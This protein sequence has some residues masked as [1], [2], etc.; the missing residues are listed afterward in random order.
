MSFSISPSRENET[1]EKIRNILGMKEFSNNNDK[2]AFDDIAKSINDI[3]DKIRQ[4]FNDLFKRAE[5]PKFNAKLPHF[6]SND[7]FY[8]F[9]QIFFVILVI[10]LILAIIYFVSRFFIKNR[11][12]KKMQ[13][14]DI[15]TSLKDWE[16]ILRTAVDYGNRGDLRQ[17]IRYLYIALLLNFNHNNIIKIDKSKTNRQ[18]TDEIRNSGFKLYSMV[19]DFT[20][21]FNTFWYGNRVPSTERF[22]YWKGNLELIIKEAENENS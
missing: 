19:R 9:I 1:K 14:I 7:S 22:E 18:Y 15:L 16:E 12:I 11:N 3:W 10:V 21:D 5:P 13:D 8:V 17:G 2:S 6:A 20:N 4:F